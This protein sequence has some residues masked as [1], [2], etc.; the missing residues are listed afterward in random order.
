MF[1]Q[2]RTYV[3]TQEN[4]V[5]SGPRKEHLLLTFLAPLHKSVLILFHLPKIVQ[6]VVFTDR[7]L[8]ATGKHSY[9][10]KSTARTSSYFTSQ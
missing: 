9:S 7:V 10:W 2:G 8:I 4:V 6:V 5:R 3:V 1:L